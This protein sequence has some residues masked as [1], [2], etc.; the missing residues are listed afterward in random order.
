MVYLSTSLE[1]FLFL[2]AG[3]ISCDKKKK[4]WHGNMKGEQTVASAVRSLSPPSLGS[5]FWA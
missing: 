5:T 1:V 2:V 4:T 3:F